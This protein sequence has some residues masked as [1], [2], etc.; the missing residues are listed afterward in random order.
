MTVNFDLCY[1]FDISMKNKRR[2]EHSTDNLYYHI[3][4]L[5]HSHLFTWDKEFPPIKFGNIK[6]T[7]FTFVF[8][9]HSNLIKCLIIIVIIET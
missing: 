7:Y 2:P 8:V 1:F 9:F 5:E 4:A 3:L 6:L